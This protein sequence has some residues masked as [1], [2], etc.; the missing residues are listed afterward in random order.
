[1]MGLEDFDKIDMDEKISETK[2]D[3]GKIIHLNVDIPTVEY[4]IHNFDEL[5]N[6]LKESYEEYINAK[7]EHDLKKSKLQTNIN[8][9][10]ENALRESNN[11]PKVTNQD[12]RNAVID[13][14]M[15]NSRIKMENC[16]MKYKFYDELF[17]FTD[18]NYELL[19]E[20]Y[21]SKENSEK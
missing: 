3:T 18:K 7:I 2:D 15:K 8:W 13:L 16:K 1:M 20:Q 11:L 19:C 6:C 14:K 9:N 21:G 10:E 17:N 4:Y 12:Q 5:F